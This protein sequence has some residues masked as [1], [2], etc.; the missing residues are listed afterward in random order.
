[1]AEEDE[2]SER[3]AQ[4]LLTEL[5]TMKAVEQIQ[6]LQ[7]VCPCGCPYCS[8]AAYLQAGMFLKQASQSSHN[9]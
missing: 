3:E 6:M 5:E 1:M 2:E 7:Q 9:E 8:S 4:L